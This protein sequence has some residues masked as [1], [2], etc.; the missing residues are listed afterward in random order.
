MIVGLGYSQQYPNCNEEGY[1]TWALA[2][3]PLH[4]VQETADSL[5]RIRYTLKNKGAAHHGYKLNP[6]VETIVLDTL[7]VY[8]EELESSIVSGDKLKQGIG[9]QVLLFTKEPKANSYPSIGS[10]LGR[11]GFDVTV[12]FPA[13]TQRDVDDM[14]RPGIFYTSAS[15]AELDENDADPGFALAIFDNNELGQSELLKGRK[16]WVYGFSPQERLRGILTALQPLGRLIVSGRGSVESIRT[17]L[18]NDRKFADEV[19]G[20]CDKTYLKAYDL[21]QG[22]PYKTSPLGLFVRHAAGSTGN[23]A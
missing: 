9:R 4:H 6:F 7:G 13:A 2:Q 1:L 22:Q 19:S 21:S 3:T 11:S 16:G 12:S 18:S 14:S 23:S 20:L 15:A 8:P 10:I 5:E 17:I